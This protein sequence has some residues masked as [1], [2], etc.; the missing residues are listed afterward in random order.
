MLTGTEYILRRISLLGVKHIFGIPGAHIYPFLLKSVG[1]GVELIINC[2][3]L[4]AGYMADGYGRASDKLGV[5]FGMGGPGSNN[6]VTAVNTARLERVPLL[7]ITGDVP[8][9]LSNVPGFQC[10]NELGTHDDAI[11][12]TIAKYSKRVSGID[13]L[14]YLI[15]EAIRIALT[16]PF[17]P[18]HL[19]IPYNVF[20]EETSAQPQPTDYARLRF[21]KN[22]RST[23]TLSRI[24]DLL[25]SDKKVI[26]W[27]GDS[28]NR[29]GP[30]Q[31]VIC[32]AEKFHIPVAT[33]FSAKGVFPEH[34]K[35]ALGNFGYAGWSLAKA[36]FLSD[37]PDVI[38]GF[39][40]EQNER[41]SL[42]WHADL[43]RGKEL[44]LVNFPGSYSN[45]EYGESIEDNP[46]YILES[47]YTSLINEVYD[48]HSR[49]RWF[50]TILQGAGGEKARPIISPARRIEPARL[51]QLL[52]KEMPRD[53]ILFVDSG[54]HRVFAGQNWKAPAAASFYSASVVAPMGWALA[55][56]IGCAFARNEPVIVFTGDG[57]MQ[58]HGIEL[59]TAIKYNRPLLVVLANNK[60]FGRIHRYLSTMSEDAAKMAGIEEV[61]WK[62]F[63]QSFGAK[64]FDITSEE[65][66]IESIRRFLAEPRLTILNVST[67]VNPYHH[68]VTLARSAF[69]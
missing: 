58:M 50:Q 23:A 27:I 59:K 44:L 41:N 52:Q 21:W 38:I 54:E 45:K 61:D 33:S 69:A 8:V 32:L 6:M 31:Q 24:R 40:I 1:T 63:G 5:L 49:E 25:A 37:S 60:A 29:A 64:V 67:P 42:G 17:G 30:A 35:L 13:D 36:M 26:F 28:L 3:E 22:D 2:H 48:R 15:E 9:H 7:V 53:A 43:Y 51:V 68:D 66:F 39:D 18:A 11:F 46:F 20:T 12:K 62:L 14:A 4:S 19:I 65:C 57:C 47:L 10:A 16:P 56:G 55:A 34:H